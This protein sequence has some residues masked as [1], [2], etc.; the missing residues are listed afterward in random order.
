M[1]CLLDT[2][3]I[4][5]MRKL[6]DRRCDPNVA[7][8]AAR[9]NTDETWLSAITILE[10]EIGILRLE[11]RDP[12][13][14]TLIRNWFGLHVLEAFEDRILP[15]D[16]AVARMCA[17]LH[18]PNPRPERDALIAATALVHNLTLITRNTNDFAG[19]GLTLF[20]PWDTSR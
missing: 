20:N 17:R 11:R 9:T 12:P 18:V 6:G 3:V 7:A 10:L 2:N 19:M 16:A 14:G 13:Q 8:W 15:V 5:E 4:S 1:I